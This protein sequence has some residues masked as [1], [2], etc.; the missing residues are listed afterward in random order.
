MNT[1][2]LFLLACA[3]FAA[4]A[5]DLANGQ[6]LFASRCASCHAVGPSA[7][8]GFGPQLNAVIGRRAGSTPDFRYSTAMVKSGIVWND[9]TLAAF[10][11]APGDLVPG[12]K[13]RFW[14][15]SDAKQVGDLL[16]Y[17]RSIPP[18]R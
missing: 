1:I 4:S 13:M 2:A 15:M 12:T 8:A 3:P 17:L 14:G 7:R 10:L 18:A 11:D 6:R 9:K 5:A 16:A